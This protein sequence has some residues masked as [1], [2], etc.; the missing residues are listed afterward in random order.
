MLEITSGCSSIESHKEVT[1][2]RR[3]RDFD[4][5][6]KILSWFRDHP[7]NLPAKLMCLDSGFIDEN[8]IVD[9]DQAEQIGA[10]IQ[11][12]LNNKP[13]PLALS[14]ERVKLRYCKAFIRP[15]Q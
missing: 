12:S 10:R 11:Q 6:F 8:N 4:D 15:Y 5:F 1:I 14:K 7:F 13:S 9:C 2:G 3:Q